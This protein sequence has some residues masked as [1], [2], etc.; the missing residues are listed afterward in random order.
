M[1]VEQYSFHLVAFR[2]A[3]NLP[4]KYMQKADACL[5]GSYTYGRLNKVRF[6][7]AV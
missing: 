7:S 3:I 4:L 2:W 1:K 6:M 5:L